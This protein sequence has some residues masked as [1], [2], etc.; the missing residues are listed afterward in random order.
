MRKLHESMLPDVPQSF[1]IAMRT[2]LDAICK[3]EAAENAL[4]HARETRREGTSTIIRK[5]HIAPKRRILIALVAALALIGSVALAAALH[6]NVFEALMGGTPTGAEDFVQ[7]DLA[8]AT[9]GNVEVRVR[10]AA[11]DGVT[12]YLLTSARD[13][14]ATECYGDV[15]ADD[16]IRY[17]GGDDDIPAV[18]HMWTDNFWI[19][20]QEVGMPAMSSS[21]EAGSDTPGEVLYYNHYRLDQWG[22]GGF[23]LDGEV[24]ISLPILERQDAREWV[25]QETKTMREPDR[26]VLQF[27]LDCSARSQTQ[28]THPNMHAPVADGMDAWISRAICS[29]LFTYLTLEYDVSQTALDAYIAENG[30]GYTDDE[31]NLLYPHT[32]SDVA[33]QIM[34]KMKLVDANGNLL[35]DTSSGIFVYGCHSVGDTEATFVFPPLPPEAKEV[36]LAPLRGGVPDLS[37][38]VRVR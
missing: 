31:G 17:L 18:G 36:Y 9:I 28:T 22:D 16:G 6:Y 35:S 27:T 10:E 12:L 3:Q 4:K 8:S 24:R 38:A 25:D 33:G 37:H 32:A 5:K 14:T 34:W 23:F 15:I 26:G 21:L 30:P 20:G 11:Y 2:T 29:P 19:N 13:L 1:D 7:H